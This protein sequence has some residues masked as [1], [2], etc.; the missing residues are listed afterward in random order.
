M[1]EGARGLTCLGLETRSFFPPLCHSGRPPCVPPAAQLPRRAPPVS[2]LIQ[3]GAYIVVSSTGR[4]PGFG[5]GFDPALVLART[6]G[7]GFGID[8]GY[9]HRPPKLSQVLALTPDPDSFLL[10]ADPVFA[11]HKNALLVCGREPFD[12][13][14]I[15]TYKGSGDTERGG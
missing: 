14:N 6:L 2:P 1:P 7:F 15:K 12:E 9:W 10:P 3:R 11:D 8:V 13:G 5:A 4:G